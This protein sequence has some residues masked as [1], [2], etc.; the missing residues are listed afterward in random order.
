MTVWLLRPRPVAGARFRLFCFPF[1]GVGPSVY[2]PWLDAL[3]GEVEA[4]LV[5]LPGREGRWRETPQ[6][7][8]EVIAPALTDALRPELDMPFAFYGHSLGA[9][10][11]FEVTRRLRALGAPMPAHLFVAAHRGPHLPNPHPEMRHLADDAFVTELRR[12]YDG[13]PQA[14]LDNPELLELMLPCLRADFEA[15][16]T[17]Q[18]LSEPPLSCPISA[19]G[20]E[21]D[22]YVRPA[23]IAGWRDQTTGRFRMR[24]LPATHFFVQSER[25]RVIGAIVEDLL[26][27]VGDAS[28]GAR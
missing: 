7:R 6:T 28:I 10:V 23:E 25:D 2:R 5:Q 12:R 18:H 13:I 8:L 11:A 24:I 27:P 14:V 3:P 19:L 9:L 1:A 22:R 16:E 15:Y 17:Y 4:R 20:G 21:H 26:Q